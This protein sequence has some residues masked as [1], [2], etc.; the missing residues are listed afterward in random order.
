MN[1]VFLSSTAKVSTKS[2]LFVAWGQLLTYDISLTVDNA[3][4]PFDVACD[5]GGG[6]VDLWCPL[7]AD[8]DDIR[9]DRSDAAVGPDF[10]RSPFN[11]ATSY[12]DLDFMYGR[13]DE[14]AKEFRAMDGG[15]MNVTDTGVPFQNAD[16]TWMIP[17]QR[18]ARFPVTFALHIM[19]LKE[20]NRCCGEVAPGNGFEEDE[21]IYLA[22]RGWTIAVFQH[23]TAD[24]YIIRL[25][26]GTVYDLAEERTTTTTT[27]IDTAEN[28]T[29]RWRG[30]RTLPDDQPEPYAHRRRLYSP[31]FYD[32][33]ANAAADVFTL[34]AGATAFESALPS[35]VRI[36]SQGYV[37][38][39]EDNVELTVACED[40]A[41]LF[42]RNNAGDILRGAV[43]SPALEVDTYFSAAVSNASPLFKLPVDAVQRGRDHGLP[44]YNDA[45]QAYGLTTA[46][47]FSDITSDESLAS[48]LSSAYGG[49]I[50]S[51]DA[52]TGALAE[53]TMASSG[54]V[55]GELLHRA[56][57]DQFIRA[58]AGDRLYHV[59]GRPMEAVANTTLS[60]V[61]NRTMNVIDL[62]RSVFVAPGV[63]VCASDCEEV[64]GKRGVALSDRFQ[65][66]WEVLDG[67]ILSISL[68]A[69]D[70]GETGMLAIGWGGTTMTDA[71]DFVIC[72]VMSAAEK[73]AECIDRST[74]PT[75][76]EPP[77]DEISPYLT[78]TEVYIGEGWT[79]V[80]FERDF[81]SLD[82]EDYDL[83]RDLDRGRDTMVIYSYKE[84]E[85]VG[86][87][88]NANRGASIINFSTG[89]A[90]A[91]CEDGEDFESLHGALMLIAWMILAPVGIYYIRYRKGEEVNWAGRQWYEMHKEIMIVTSEAVLPLGITA[92]VATG[93]NH[94]TKH[95]HWGYYMIAAVA[96]QVITGWIRTKGLEA[97]HANFSFVHR[98]NKH[99]HIWAGRF[100]YLSGVVQCYRGV[101]LVSGGDELLLSTFDGMDVELGSFRTIKQYVF[102]VWFAAISIIVVFLESHK[103]Y[104]RFFN[105]GA[106]NCA[107]VTVVN[108]EHFGANS[109]RTT[110]RLMPRTEEVEI[111]SVKEFNHKVLNGQSWVLVDGAVLDVSRFFQRHP[112]GARLIL[113]AVGTDVTHEL[114]GQDLSVGHAMSFPPHV[115][116][117]RAWDIVRSLVVGYIEEEDDLEQHQDQKQ[118]QHQDQKERDAD[119]MDAVERKESER[120]GKGG[121]FDFG[122]NGLAR[123][124]STLSVGG[125]E[126]LDDSLASTARR[127]HRLASIS[128]SSS[129]LRDFGP[130]TGTT[131]APVTGLKNAWRGAKLLERFHVCPLLFR[132]KMLPFGRVGPS[133]SKIKRPVYRY[134]FSCPG[135]AQALGVVQ[136][137][138]NAFPVRVQDTLA[139]TTSRGVTG[140]G[141][142][143]GSGTR[144]VTPAGETTEGT[145]CIE[146][147]IRLHRDGTMSKL[148]D[149]LANDT[150]NP[151]VQLQGPFVIKQLAPPPAHRT[152]VMI[153]AG[154]GINPMLQQIRLYMGLPRDGAYSSRSRLALVW[155]C[156]SE[157][158]LYGTDEITEM[159]TKSNGLLE[160]TVLISGHH[161]KR[162]IPGAAFGLAKRNLLL[163]A[164]NLISP[165]SSSTA[166]SGHKYTTDR[167]DPGT[168]NTAK[169]DVPALARCGVKR[170]SGLGAAKDWL[171]VSD[172]NATV[173][174]PVDTRVTGK[175]TRAVLEKVF[176]SSLLATLKPHDTGPTTNIEGVLPRAQSETEKDG[177]ADCETE[178]D[179]P[180]GTDS[181]D[182]KLQVVVSGPGG[183][184]FSVETILTEMGVPSSAVVLLD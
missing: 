6:V 24:D 129:V 135:Q 50:D 73:A 131:A 43:L 66:S 130:L 14:E 7:G 22:C 18:T 122:R 181:A 148:L 91:H 74:T 152:V 12:I 11:Y 105:K 177:G 48:L 35:T 75:H 70:I 42:Q 110:M 68:R 103:Q 127:L 157:A 171:V 158:D 124:G 98:C 15:L 29:R 116:Q 107:C 71:Q 142:R 4:D 37:S 27:G 45:R 137:S 53:G 40:I 38:V 79:T 151:A 51:V 119:M 58:I 56:W 113:N 146:L 86:Q 39:A 140:A 155:Q 95:A 166:I 44:T 26:G 96:A 108:E 49:D 90:D 60:D 94:T 118:G 8:S 1:D 128:V 28:P 82:D 175:V 9:F 132:E 20:H 17:D 125:T 77:P 97:K 88:P 134:I 144:T 57:L 78:V 104:R 100:A 145:L 109:G 184:V 99:F 52:I 16:G 156:A 133:D 163:N 65:I 154:T 3:S 67:E 54:G 176:G 178:P 167:N 87:H 139:S 30:R 106:A 147:R 141:A 150:D 164:R 84:G 126:P 149:N 41:G 92:V 80:T 182:G 13:S 143:A 93:G 34:T 115:H 31:D 153:A 165:A 62:P 47:D 121:F 169:D 64:V 55:F 172:P 85:G 19:L 161:R 72:E 168:V 21:E 69:K 23:M 83:K 5:D 123:V 63:T 138:Y 112:G 179:V 183:F 76:T 162:N 170:D 25:F 102:P 89:N 46:T 159:Q 61:I 160:V 2:A 32:Q 136:R 117:E 180:P 59:H 111:Y 174:N 114:L 33:T 36:V 10:V 101:E 173:P 81:A 120:M